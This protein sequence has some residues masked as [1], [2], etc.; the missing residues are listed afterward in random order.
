MLSCTP[1]RAH[2]QHQLRRRGGALRL[3]GGGD[4]GHL[5]REDVG[6]QRDLDVGDR[7]GDDFD[8]DELLGVP[9]E[10]DPDPVPAGRHL[11]VVAAV[12]VG[13]GDVGGADRL[14]R[15]A[16]QGD[17]VG[18]VDDL[19]GHPPRVLGRGGRGAQ[20]QGRRQP[21]PE[22]RSPAVLSAQPG[23]S[24]A[25]KGDGGNALLSVRCHGCNVT[26]RL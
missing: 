26:E 19:S 2:P 22:P 1:G 16:G 6:R 11:E 9:A 8:V 14:D 21:D 13:I 20:Q 5:L 12:E 15:H 23:S 4:D 17:R 24:A 7:P 25:W 3:K 18:L 10:R